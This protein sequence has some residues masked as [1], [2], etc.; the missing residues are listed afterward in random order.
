MATAGGTTQTSLKVVR[1]TYKHD[2]L[3]GLRNNVMEV[4]SD[5]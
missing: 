4:H 3:Y 1:T 5:K 2:T